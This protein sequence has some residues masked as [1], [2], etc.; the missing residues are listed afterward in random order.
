[1]PP[2]WRPP[3]GRERGRTVRDMVGRIVAGRIMMGRRMTWR[4]GVLCNMASGTPYNNRN[5]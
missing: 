2:E 1:M 5:T 3:C 4:D